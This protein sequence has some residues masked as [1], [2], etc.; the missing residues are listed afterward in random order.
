[1]NG[2]LLS[3]LFVFASL[4]W[5]LRD[6]KD[7][8]RP[9]LFMAMVANLFYGWAL[10]RFLG[11][12]DS[13]V[14]WKFDYY[15]Y[16]LDGALRVSSAMVGRAFGSGA[17]GIAL[18]VVYDAMIPMM[19]VFYRAAGRE[20]RL[21]MAYVAEL[22]A[23]PCCYA[24]LP[25]LGP[26]YVFGPAWLRSPSA[27]I[28]LVKFGGMPNA[29]PS[30]HFA[31]SLLFIQFAPT[32]G[33][34]VVSWLFA[35]GTVLAT[36]ATGEHYV[37]DLAVAVP[38]SCFAAGVARGRIRAGLVQLAIVAGWILTIRYGAG[39]LIAN[40]PVP[41][42]AVALTLAS[43]VLMFAG[44]AWQKGGRKGS[45][46]PDQADEQG[47]AAYATGRECPP[48][49]IMRSDTRFRKA[50]EDEWLAGSGE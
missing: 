6:P 27:G 3:L 1:V 36:L 33:W 47:A 13:L 44:R 21:L 43:P 46:Y 18:L 8:T 38:F 41:G 15:L 24:A 10:S 23:G 50:C 17:P 5:M 16:R 40:P 4:V 9:I 34:R 35:A 48:A 7:R 2:G 19:I 45:A 20:S 25:A 28:E 26:A 22:L 29:F 32:R 14:P 37:I 31:T 30:L 12:V 42:A 11:S 49:P 39:W